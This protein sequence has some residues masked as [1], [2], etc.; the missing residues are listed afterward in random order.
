[1]VSEIKRSDT[2]RYIKVSDSRPVVDHL[3]DTIKKRLDSGQRV[4]W[5]IP[6]GSAIAIAVAVG[7]RLADVDARS[8]HVTLTD[9][10][11]GPV[12]HRDSNWQQLID[13]GFDIPSAQLAPVLTGDDIDETIRAFV[14]YLE[15]QLASAD[16]SIGLF[17]MGADG[18]TAGV[19]PGD[20]A[21][22][23]DDLVKH[24]SAD[25]YQRVTMTLAAIARLD[26]AAVYAVGPEK[27]DALEKLQ[28]EFTLEEQPAQ[29]L[30]RVA[31]STIYNDL[32]GDET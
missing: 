2:I 3:A 9:E 23:G 29:I 14:V 17:G 21:A 5:L 30:K 15:T 32:R 31:V 26:E 28:K 13:A 16:Y 27:I 10:R 12:G 8:L 25:D 19:L 6:G 20:S 22:I 1:M 7:K 18:H 4:F 24:Y 11:Y